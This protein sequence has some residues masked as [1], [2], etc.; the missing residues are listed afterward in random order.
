MFHLMIVCKKADEWYIEWQQVATSGTMSD[1]EWQRGTTN[2][3]E[4]CNEWQ[5]VG[6]RMTTSRT[7]SDTASD[8]E[9]QQMITSGTTNENE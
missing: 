6:K 9:W 2:D 1:N 3:K 8:N 7:T 4:W 5:Q